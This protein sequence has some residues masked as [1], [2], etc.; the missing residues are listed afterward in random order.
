MNTPTMANHFAEPC[1]IDL[2]VAHA[3]SAMSSVRR[4][5]G[6]LN[7]NIRTATEVSATT[8][9]ASRPAP[10]PK[11]RLTVAYSTPTVATPI[12]TS[13]SRIGAELARGRT[14]RAMTHSAAGGLSTVMELPASEEPKKNASAAL[15]AAWTAAE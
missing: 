4:A 6:L 9:P 14:D 2:I 5:S 13:G 11:W 12:S 15:A 3:P 7:R 10:A 8:T 1:S